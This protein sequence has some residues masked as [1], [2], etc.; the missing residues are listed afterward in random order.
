MFKTKDGRLI[1]LEKLSWSDAVTAIS[2][3]APDL[4]Q[5]MNK[6]EDELDCVF[7]KASYPFGGQIINNG[8]CYLPLVDGGSIAFDDQDF[9]DELRKDLNY[10]DKE[11][12][13]AMILSKNS[14]FYL[15]GNAEV[16][17]QAIIYPG[18]MFGIPKAIDSGV[19]NT[20]TSALELNLNAGSRSLFMLSKI[21]DQ[22]YHAKIQEYYGITLAAPIDPQ[23]HWGIFVQIA[24]KS[25]SLWRAEVLYFSRTWINQLETDEWAAVAK[26]LTNIHRASYNLWH[27]VSDTWTKTFYEIEREKKLSKYYSMQSI[28]V[29]KQ[30]FMLAAG[31]T[32][33]F[34][35]ATTE[36]AAPIKVIIEAYT[37]VYNKLA[38]QKHIPVMMEAAKLDIESREPIYYSINHALST[39]EDLEASKNKSQITRLDEIRK[40]VEN[41]TKTILEENRIESLRNVAKNTVFSYYHG[42]P[43][44][45]DK[46]Q[47]PQVLATDDTRFT[48]GDGDTFPANSLFFTGCIKISHS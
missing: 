29:A 42:R 8:K 19:T 1:A 12:P 37:N 33:G 31:I 32:P 11:D 39:A 34:K 24:N 14:E 40:I 3:R 41:Y 21:S 7:Y 13:L 26:R 25:N 28:N 47:N 9:P 15:P 18:Q 2:P 48:N 30:L 16:Q 44:S 4:A 45:Y 35:P 23:D 20:S 43:E 17:P 5:I 27:K 6:V 10:S 46:V 22:V 38:K 36:D